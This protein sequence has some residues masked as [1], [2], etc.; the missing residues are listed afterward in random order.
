M[1]PCLIEREMTPCPLLDQIQPTKMYRLVQPHDHHQPTHSQQWNSATCD[2]AT[3]FNLPAEHIHLWIYTL[4]D[5]AQPANQYAASLPIAVQH[6]AARMI[7]VHRKLTFEC[8][9]FLLRHLLSH[10]QEL[11]ITDLEV[12]KTLQG[13]WVW[14]GQQPHI[15]FNLSHS[16]EYIAIAFS[17]SYALG[18]DIERKN[19]AIDLPSLAQASCSACEWRYWQACPPAQQLDWFYTLWNVK[20]AYLKAIGTGAT[21]PLSNACLL[22]LMPTDAACSCRSISRRAFHIAAIE[23]YSTALMAIPITDS[24]HPFGT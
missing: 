3:R 9:Q 12:S 2:I 20:E 11:P 7:S 1:H 16:A 6:Q 19:T 17:R 5:L 18:V 24:G 22:N 21:Q 23:G 13:K 14:S 15:E 4:S 8:G 10:Y